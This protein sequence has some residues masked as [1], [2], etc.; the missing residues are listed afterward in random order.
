MKKLLGS[1]L[2]LPL[3]LPAAAEAGAKC[4]SPVYVDA[5]QRYARGALG[6]ARNST[7]GI[8]NISCNIYSWGYVFCQARSASSVSGSC[9]TSDP[10]FISMMQAMDESAYVYFSWDASGTCTNL[11]VVNDSCY[12]PKQP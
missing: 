6:A 3:M 8:Q 5:T 2:L 9:G 7:D 4:A 1:L 10:A 11:V 12:E